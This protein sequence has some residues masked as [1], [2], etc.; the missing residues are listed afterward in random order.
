M[1]TLDAVALAALRRQQ[2]NAVHNYC[3][4]CTAQIWPNYCR[5]CDEQFT[6]GHYLLKDGDVKAVCPDASPHQRHR[7]Y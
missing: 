4:L 3:Q 7:K 2:E 5:T 6:D 1:P